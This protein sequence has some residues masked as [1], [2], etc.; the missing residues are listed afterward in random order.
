[1]MFVR[2]RY[3]LALFICTLITG[4]GLA[5]GVFASCDGNYCNT[6]VTGCTPLHQPFQESC[7]R[8]NGSGGH[9]CYTCWR[10]YY[11]CDSSLFE[12]SAYNCSGAGAACS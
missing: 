2:L 1:M 4:S 12:G 7:C 9:N 10:D 11:W 6:D 3:R 8:S 5:A